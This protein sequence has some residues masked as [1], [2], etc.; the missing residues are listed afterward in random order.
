MANST[1]CVAAL[2]PFTVHGHNF[3]YEWREH[4]AENLKGT[5]SPKKLVRYLELC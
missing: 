2:I 3:K 5:H 4:V 1:C